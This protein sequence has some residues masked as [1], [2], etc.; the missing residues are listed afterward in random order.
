MRFLYSIAFYL[1]TPFILLHFAIRGL[2]DRR[3][4]YRWSERFAVYA[5]P[6]LKESVVIHAASVG[7]LIA[8]EPLLKQLTLR[9]DTLPVTITTFT[10]TSSA[11]AQTYSADTVDHFYAPLDLPGAVKRFFDAFQPRL[12]IIMETEIWPNLFAEAGRRGIPILMANARM[13][14]KSFISYRRFATI[15][16]EALEQTGFV[17]AQSQTDLNRLVACGVSPDRIT[18]PGNMKYD[19]TIP[20]G[21]EEASEK[22]RS[23][24]GENRPV[25]I[26]AS[27]HEEDDLA[28]LEAFQTIQQAFPDTLLIVVPR[29]P[30][31]FIPAARH[32]ERGGLKTELFSDSDVC[33]E[34]ARC[35]VIDTMGKLMDYYACS[36]VAIVGGSFGETGGHNVLEASAL[37]LPVIVGP[38]TQNFSEITNKLITS[39][40]GYQVSD[41]VGLANRTIELLGSAEKRKAMGNAGKQIVAQGRGALLETL[42]VVERLL[43]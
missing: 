7:E 22:L 12:L 1:S 13:S 18:A 35:F 19:L 30:E 5:N 2:R 40:A 31:R 29:H 11:R 9:P 26:A 43:S 36:D 38:N 42:S 16:R 4:F 17:L 8:A 21:I 23:R 20:T 10:P 37:G 39:G 32:Y 28:I 3:Y 27:T 41:S 34:Q 25:V 24:W 33:S 6:G 15:A 14:S